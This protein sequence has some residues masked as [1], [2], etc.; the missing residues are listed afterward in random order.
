MRLK[1][2]V[3]I[4]LM[5]ILIVLV[6]GI[7][8]LILKKDDVLTY[9]NTIT[10]NLNDTLPEEIEYTIGKEHKKASVTW[11]SVDTSE[12]GTYKGTFK[13]N[14]KTYDIELKVKDTESPT[15]KG[16]KDI[17]ITVGENID[18]LENITVEDNTSE[19]IKATIKGK[20]DLNKE[21]T[22]NLYYEAT[23]KSG[24]TAKEEFT[25]TVTKK[26]QDNPHLIGPTGP[27]DGE[28]YVIGKSS[29]GYTIEV[30]NGITYVDGILIANK[31]YPLPSTYAPGFLQEANYAYDLLRQGA[32]AEGLNIYTLNSYRSYIDQ[33]IIYNDYVNRD[34]KENAD[35]YSARPGHS[36]HQSGLAVDVNSLDQDWENTTEGKW[37]SS[38]CYKYGFIIRY[39]KGKENI[40][41]Y[42]YEPW[43]IRYVG[44]DLA[45]KLYNNGK[46]ITL[47][48]YLGIDSKYTY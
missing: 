47:E 13:V 40:T 46:W 4:T 38:N 35:T 3:R 34:G 41:G 23:D 24:N 15:I 20:Y 33:K 45:E 18:L 5:I 39:P 48:E 32:K 22:Y 17:E 37:L 30:I 11:D 31:T 28:S 21:G 6:A 14:D 43:H 25:L 1:K 27:S 2:K 16:V 8:Y 19:N 26:G 9:N 10:I 29:K 7:I 12:I 36:E 42:I 44:T